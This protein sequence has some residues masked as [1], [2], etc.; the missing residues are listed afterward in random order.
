MTLHFMHNQLFLNQQSY[1]REG[2]ASSS[3]AHGVIVE[4]L[5]HCCIPNEA[6]VYQA[7]EANLKKMDVLKCRGIEGH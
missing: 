7:G 1:Q 3:Q 5:M 4:H 2:A 6:V